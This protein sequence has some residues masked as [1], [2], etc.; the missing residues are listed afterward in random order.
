MTTKYIYLSSDVSRDIHPQNNGALFTNYL[1]KEVIF[2]EN[3]KI[4]LQSLTLD[5]DFNKIPQSIYK[6]DEHI[7]I[8][9]HVVY[10]VKGSSS[11]PILK[12]NIKKGIK[13]N[14]DLI[15]EIR[16]KGKDYFSLTK[17]NDN[18][19]EFT[20]RKGFYILIVRELAKYLGIRTRPALLFNRDG[21]KYNFLYN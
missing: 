10:K 15:E 12:I 7:L 18:L 20:M 16:E 5:N 9:N 4:A 21:V 13:D 11:R 17:N 6:T 2:K 3:Q 8:I 1:S 14:N 19:L